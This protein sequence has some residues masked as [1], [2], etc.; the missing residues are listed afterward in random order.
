MTEEEVKEAV[1]NLQP[2]KAPGPDGFP[3]AFY[4]TFWQI[5]KKDLL[6]MVIYVMRKRK[7]GGYTNSTLLALI[8]KYPRPS[9]LNCFRPISLCNNSYKIISKIIAARM[10][11]LLLNLITENQG[12]FVPNRQIVDN[13][14][15]VQEDIHTSLNN[16]EKGFVLKMDMANAFDRVNLSFLADVLREFGF[17][18]EFFEL[19]QP[20][21]MGPW[22]APLINGRP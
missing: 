14:I 17:S 1:W 19:I 7:I 10:K 11:P 20:C 13:I 18:E 22:I 12:G 6:K 9:T 3:I 21:T 2:D 16:N 5:I 8:P 15:L 4:R